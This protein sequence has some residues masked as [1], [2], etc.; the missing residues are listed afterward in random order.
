M[1]IKLR[2]VLLSAAGLLLAGS[3]AAQDINVDYKKYPDA[4]PFAGRDGVKGSPSSKSAAAGTARS[5]TYG[6]TRPDHVNNALTK[7]YPP[8]FNQDGG[9]C[10]SAAAVG[11]YETGCGAFVRCACPPDGDRVVADRRASGREPLFPLARVL[12]FTVGVQQQA[13]AER[14]A[15]ALDSQEP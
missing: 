7:Y 15:A 8:V 4:K 1:K 14:A 6:K 12:R 2:N 3:V 9:S 11:V 10:G 5:A 13:S